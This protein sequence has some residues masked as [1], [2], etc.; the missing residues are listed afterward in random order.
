MGVTVN[1]VQV[2]IDRGADNATTIPPTNRAHRLIL[3]NT[4]LLANEYKFKLFIAKI[5]INLFNLET[6]L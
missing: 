4:T 1:C 5:K 3:E 6:L 2:M